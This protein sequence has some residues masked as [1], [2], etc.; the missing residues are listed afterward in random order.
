M[1]EITAVTQDTFEKEVLQA[2]TPVL[3]DF[4]AP[5]C[6]PCRALA[7]V[8]EAVA[9]EYAGKIK[10]AKVNVDEHPALAS[11]YGIVSIPSL[12]LFKNGTVAENLVGYI[13][14]RDLRAKLQPHAG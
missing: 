10:F 11:K 3:V 8:L 9:K 1:S 14:D 12:F 5:W 13:S 2:S 4:W 6:V 7:L